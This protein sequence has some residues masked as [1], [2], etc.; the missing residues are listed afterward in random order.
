MNRL[1][2]RNLDEE[3]NPTTLT[4]KGDSRLT[5]ETGNDILK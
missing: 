1:E 4:F 5:N 2:P 3:G